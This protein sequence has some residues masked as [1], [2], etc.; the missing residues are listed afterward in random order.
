[1]QRHCSLLK[2]LSIPQEE[3][4]ETWMLLEYCDRGSLSFA[5][6]RGKLKDRSGNGPDMVHPPPL[7]MHRTQEKATEI[8]QFIL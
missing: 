5:V 2:S 1:M 7:Q 4:L 6:E 8:S 3:Y